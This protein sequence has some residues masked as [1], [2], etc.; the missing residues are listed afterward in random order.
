MPK[1]NKFEKKSLSIEVQVYDNGYILKIEVLGSNSIFKVVK[2]KKEV[3]RLID[4]F[5][6]PL[7]NQK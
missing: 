7:K 1:K 2:T 6:Y 5:L 3:Y 4:Y